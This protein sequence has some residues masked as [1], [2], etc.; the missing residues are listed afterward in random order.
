[1]NKASTTEMV[2]VPELHDEMMKIINEIQN[3]L[4]PVIEDKDAS[5]CTNALIFITMDLCSFNCHTQ[6]DIDVVFKCLCDVIQK[7][8]KLSVWGQK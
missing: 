8:S 5:L 4:I 2:D 7:N 3:V 1:M 6:E